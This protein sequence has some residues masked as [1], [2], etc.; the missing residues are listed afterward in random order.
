ML[1]DHLMI[2]MRIKALG[3]QFEGMI[4]VHA[5]EI[6]QSIQQAI[7][8]YCSPDNLQK[9]IQEQIDEAIRKELSEQIKSFFGYG[10]DGKSYISEN[11]KN[12]LKRSIDEQI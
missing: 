12:L 7:N 5:Q 10:G 4:H 6:K 11:I 3:E 8:N 1:Q 9:V 2:N